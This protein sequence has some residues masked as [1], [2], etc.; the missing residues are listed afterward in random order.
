M[1]KKIK[2]FFACLIAVFAV[3]GFSNTFLLAALMQS[4]NY[5]IEAEDSLTPAGGDW[6]S[7]NY[8]FRDTMGEVSTGR[9]DSTSY[10][11]RAGYQEM[12]EVYI[13]VSAPGDLDLAPSIPGISGGTADGNLT[14]TVKADGSAGFAMQL[15]A[16]T[17]PAMKLPADATYYF[18]DYSPGAPGVPDYTW[19]VTA[20]NSG[21]GFTV[22]PETAGDTVRAFLDNGSN[23]CNQAAG[24]Q[25]ADKC[26]LNFNGTT[27]VSAINRS[28]RTST[29]GE[30][31]VVKFKAQ[32]NGKFLK[33]GEYIATI[34]TLVT[35]N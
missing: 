21:F 3:F 33:E 7:S 15:K 34:T 24:S 10:E 29:D 16:A 26:W 30:D 17:T 23:A 19:S 14:W 18:D 31:E 35:S 20:G 4:T 32:S 6:T 22:E 25:T 9:S 13:S 11:M 1:D 28:S 2:T 5:I 12:L 8:V 27:Y